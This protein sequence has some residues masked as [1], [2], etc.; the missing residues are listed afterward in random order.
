[1]S[2]KTGDAS[3]QYWGADVSGLWIN[4]KGDTGT[5]QPPRKQ[6]ARASNIYLITGL[7]ISKLHALG[8][9][10]IER[11]V[12]ILKIDQTLQNLSALSI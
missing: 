12:F 7:T 6:T 2:G 3:G 8:K 9:S 5:E 4:I 1:V 11:N 10:N